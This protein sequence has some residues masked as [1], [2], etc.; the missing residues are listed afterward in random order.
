METGRWSFIYPFLDDF[1]YYK[2][3]TV[4][5]AVA[6]PI[7]GRK[8]MM[9]RFIMGLFIASVLF[10]GFGCSKPQNAEAP[11]A[12]PA[13]QEEQKKGADQ[14]DENKAGEKFKMDPR[15]ADFFKKAEDF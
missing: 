10:I 7:A 11:K 5:A 9:L 12:P 8:T 14:A 13:A 4:L 3:V 2:P 15:A 1:G 6:F